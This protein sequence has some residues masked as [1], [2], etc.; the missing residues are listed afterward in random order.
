MS[1][2]LYDLAT[3]VLLFLSF[4]FSL[5]LSFSLSW[6]LSS[7]SSS[8]NNTFLRYESIISSS[9]FCL[10][11]IFFVSSNFLIS[12]NLSCLSCFFFNKSFAHISLMPE[13]K[14]INL[15]LTILHSFS[16]HP[17]FSKSKL[18]KY[19]L[20]NSVDLFFCFFFMVLL[21]V[22]FSFLFKFNSGFRF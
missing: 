17:Y 13:T 10:F 6:A 18:G 16:V 9:F 2:T 12:S 1:S 19:D 3:L 11:S 7:F 4:S 22:S 21:L 15:F 5:S 8:N 14:D 20:I